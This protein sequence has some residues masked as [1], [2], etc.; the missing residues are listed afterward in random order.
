MTK[1]KIGALVSILLTAVIAIAALFYPVQVPYDD[2]ITAKAIERG[3]LLCASES[4]NCVESWNGSDFII[5][6][7]GGSTQKY[8]V[9]GATGNVDAEGTANFAGAVTLQ[10]AL[11]YGANNLYPVG[12]ASSGQQLVYGT[13]NVTGTI[14]AAHGLTTVTFC[15]ATLNEDPTA[16]AGDGAMVTVVVAA[17]V[18]TLKVW[19]DDFVTAATETN[20]SVQWLV[21]GV[22]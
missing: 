10:G 16:G 13:T 3:A 22:P 2:N 11:Q 14:V 12:Y 9:D 8:H 19:Q 18:C 5:Y 6:S 7:D 17:N 21:V 4:G 15:T 1:V 20:V